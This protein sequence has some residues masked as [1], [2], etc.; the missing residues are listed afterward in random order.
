MMAPALCIRRWRS[1]S[2]AA[3]VAVVGIAVAISTAARPAETAHKPTRIVSINL[4]AYELVLRLAEIKN[5]V[6]VS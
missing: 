5:V 3:V 4:C 2:N 1:P 6:S